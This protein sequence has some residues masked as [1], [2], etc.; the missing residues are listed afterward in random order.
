MYEYTEAHDLRSIREKCPKGYLSRLTQLEIIASRALFTR[1]LKEPLKE[2]DHV[3]MS[4]FLCGDSGTSKTY[5]LHEL[6]GETSI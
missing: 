6:R 5:W 1:V 4:V 3:Q 2:G